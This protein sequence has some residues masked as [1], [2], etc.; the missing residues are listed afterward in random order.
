MAGLLIRMWA[1]A[2]GRTLR[3]VVANFHFGIPHHNDAGKDDVQLLYYNFAY[4]QYFGDS[5]SDQGGEGYINQAF[6]GAQVKVRQVVAAL[7]PGQGVGRAPLRAGAVGFGAV[8]YELALRGLV[9][10]LRG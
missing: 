3:E 9:A 7:G 1:L 6:P 2:S 5:V 10:T 4:H 8:G